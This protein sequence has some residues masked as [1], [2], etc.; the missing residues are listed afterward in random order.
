MKF[1]LQHLS[2]TG[3]ISIVW[4]QHVTSGSCIGRKDVSILAESSFGWCWS[5][6]WGYHHLG[7]PSNSDGK[8]SACNA[9]DR[10]LIHGLERSP[11]KGNGYPLQYSFLENPMDRAWWATV[12][13]IVKSQ[14]WLATNIHTHNIIY[15]NG[16]LWQLNEMLYVRCLD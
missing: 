13:G 10:G 8:E 2:H 15:L 7:F 9:W 6:E 5:I 4:Y 12:H 3:H 16:L 11:G 14:T 1:N